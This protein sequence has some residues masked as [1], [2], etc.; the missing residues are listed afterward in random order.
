M[1]R[2]V[3]D[4]VMFSERTGFKDKK[5]STQKILIIVT[6]YYVIVWP[7][8]FHCLNPYFQKQVNSIII[9]LQ[10]NFLPVRYSSL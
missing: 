10:F 2:R 3:K 1:V 7:A 6:Y 8:L 4:L 9:I 5:K